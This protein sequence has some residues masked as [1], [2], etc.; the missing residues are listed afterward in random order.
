MAAQYEAS[1][2]TPLGGSVSPNSWNEPKDPNTDPAAG[3]NLNYWAFKDRSGNQMAFNHE[4]GYENML[5]EHRTGSKL[6]MM[7]DGAV[8]LRS[9]RGKYEMTFGPDRV[10]VTGTQDI[11]VEGGGSLRVNGEYNVTV[12]KDYNLTVGGGFNVKSLNANINTGCLDIGA[13]NI[14]A[15]ASGGIALSAAGAA[16][17]I[18]ESGGM[19]IGST[20][21]SVAIGAGRQV[22]IVAK[23]GDLMLDATA[24]RVGATGTVGVNI[25]SL[26]GY[27]NIA[28][29]GSSIKMATGGLM[30]IDATGAM[31]IAGGG[32]TKLSA[33]G[34]MSV[35]AATLNLNSAA[36]TAPVVLPPDLTTTTKTLIQTPPKP[37]PCGDP[38]TIAAAAAGL[39]AGTSGASS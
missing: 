17:F 12:G 39:T 35:D 31:N 9:H 21:N 4:R 25:Q 22:G 28:A 36:P 11:V 37:T 6:Q 16:T 2:G 18:S 30:S 20:L 14:N 27:V 1:G 5:F 7:P 23:G 33:A 24:G 38:A 3:K 26:A 19:T 13:K 15:V 34:A 32:I 10:K 8:V 29:I